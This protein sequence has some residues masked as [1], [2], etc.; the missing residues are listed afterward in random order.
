MRD[1]R[2]PYTWLFP[3]GDRNPQ[4][5]PPPPDPLPLYLEAFSSLYLSFSRHISA[6][7]SSLRSTFLF[8]FILLTV[9][10]L[11]VS[12]FPVVISLVLS[13]S[14]PLLSV[15]LPSIHWSSLNFVLSWFSLSLLPLSLSFYL[16][17]S[18]FPRPPSPWSFYLLCPPSPFFILI[19]LCCTSGHSL[20]SS[21]PLLSKNISLITTSIHLV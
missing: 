1:C 19:P 18:S 4:N 13:Q 16:D 11:S 12:S 14:L 6:L 9:S 8:S 15:F 2:R 3:L 10:L 7:W 21:Q 5:T 17:S 20:L